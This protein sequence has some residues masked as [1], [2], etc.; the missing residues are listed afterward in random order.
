MHTRKQMKAHC[1][2]LHFRCA[3][4]LMVPSSITV[5]QLIEMMKVCVVYVCTLVCVSVCV[6]VCLVRVC[7]VLMYTYDIYLY[8]YISLSIYRYIDR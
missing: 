6:C 8:I 7:C 5:A 4:S 3:V 1:A 2:Y